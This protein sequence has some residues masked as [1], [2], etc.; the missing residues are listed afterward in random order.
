MKHGDDDKRVWYHIVLF[1][2]EFF[3]DRVLGPISKVSSVV[4]HSVI[5]KPHPNSTNINSKYKK[6]ELCNQLV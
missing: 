4:S 6:V 3:H 1:S 5:T 2:L